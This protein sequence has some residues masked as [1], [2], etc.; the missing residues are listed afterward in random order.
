MQI[1]QKI[2]STNQ[3]ME[4][5]NRINAQR[6]IASNQHMKFDS[7]NR[8]VKKKCMSHTRID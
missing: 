7:I 1:H 8:S 2:I 5:L 4:A 3:K 6:K